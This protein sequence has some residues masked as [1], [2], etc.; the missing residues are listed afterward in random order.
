MDDNDEV[1]FVQIGDYHIIIVRHIPKLQRTKLYKINIHISLHFC[2][3]N[4]LMPNALKK[5][6]EWIDKG[7]MKN[8]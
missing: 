6:D 3:E 8:I 2:N 1:S 5:I 4:I 7:W